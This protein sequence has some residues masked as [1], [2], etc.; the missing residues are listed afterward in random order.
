MNG[1]G[2]GR[3]VR[4]ILPPMIAAAPADEFILFIESANVSAIP[5]LGKNVRLSPVELTVAP[6]VAAAAD[7]ARSPK[8]M[9]RMTRAVGAEKTDVFFFPTVYTYFPMP[10]GPMTARKR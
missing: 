9:L 8:D 1:R 5:A 7:G 10:L 3:F 6:T 4:E 2:Y